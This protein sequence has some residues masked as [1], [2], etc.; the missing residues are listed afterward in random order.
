VAT[1]VCLPIYEPGG[2]VSGRPTTDVIGCR[3]VKLSGAKD[4]ASLGLAP[5][6][7]GGNIKIAPAGAGDEPVGV[8][9]AD[10][11]ADNR[12]SSIVTVLCMNMVVPIE[13]AVQLQP[14]DWVNVAAGGKAGKAA[15]KA[16]ACARC[17]SSTPPGQMAV[18]KLGT[19][20]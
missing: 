1:N 15:D 11:A 12:Q 2:R 17:W 14:G 9:E 4:P 3:F 16:S 18:I 5:T 19:S 7:A 6:G 10:C 8:A 20:L 13:A